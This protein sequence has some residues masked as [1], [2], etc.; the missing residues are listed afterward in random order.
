MISEE[1]ISNL[2]KEFRAAGMD[3]RRRPWEAVHRYS[4]EFNTSV[5]LSSDVA[6][7]IFKWFKT[8]SKPGVHQLDALYEA[9]YFYDAQFWIVSIPVLA[10]TVQLNAL[11]CLREMPDGIKQEMMTDR[12]QAWD[13]SI[14]WADCVDYGM[15]IDDLRKTQG[16]N[17]FGAQLL[18][19]AYQEL[20]ASTSILSQ[21]RP[22]P[23]AILNCRMALEMFFKSYI[24]LKNG[25]SQNQAMAIGH[26]LNN[27]LDEFIKASGL[28]Y[29]EKTRDILSVFPEISERYKEQDTT[30]QRLWDG[31]S[32][33]HS[34]GTGIIREFTNRNTLKQVIQETGSDSEVSPRISSHR[35]VDCGAYLTPQHMPTRPRRFEF[36]QQFG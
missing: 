34:V 21:H 17:E 3:Q 4:E 25:L 7:T 31:Y 6:K 13:Y 22:D 1:W 14:Y 10:G 28:N 36:S 32:L 26:D 18:L 30:F 8:H 15:G 12:R 5:D 24:A 20:R 11:D 33:A 16:L 23:R 27:G 35:A 9:V 29:W 19:S 2:N